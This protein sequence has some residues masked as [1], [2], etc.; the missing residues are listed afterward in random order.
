MLKRWGISL[1]V[2]AVSASAAPAAIT[3]TGA[4]AA[5]AG[6]V[7]GGAHAA[8][9]APGTGTAR[10]PVSTPVSTGP[11]SPDAAPHREGAGQATSTNWSGYAA[12]GRA[13]TSV[14]AS[15]TQPRVSCGSGSAYSSFWVGLDGYSSRTVE[16]IGADSDC[17]GGA[18]Y[19]GWYEMYPSPSHDF[20]RA[21]SADDVM[22]A[23]VTYIGRGSF[24]L[25]LSDETKKWNAAVTRS[26]PGATRRSAEVV[27]EA[28]SSSSGIL[29][30]A[31]FG[32]TAVAGARADGRALG[33]YS[34]T[35]ITMAS[36]G[37]AAK[38]TISP[39]SHGGDFRVTWKR[40]S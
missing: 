16:Q 35:R 2:L 27:I 30:L 13:Y 4:A 21:I 14:E 7:P 26:L 11:G 9:Y 32:A 37:G 8:R 34:P 3:G 39:L 25:A 29:P 1:A 38:D 40:A 20:H 23:S 12:S 5:T 17:S 10:A 28:P 6:P 31:H 33:G 36:G 22:H 24:R 19:Y 18:R 15:W